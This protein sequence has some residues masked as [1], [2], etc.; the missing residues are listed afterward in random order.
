MNDTEAAEILNTIRQR[1]RVTQIDEPAWIRKLRK[2]SAATALQ[3]LTKAAETERYLLPAH[4]DP[5]EPGNTTAWA[6]E[7]TKVQQHFGRLG[8]DGNYGNPHTN[9]AVYASRH[10]IRNQPANQAQWT[11]RD[12]YE[13]AANNHD[14]HP[15]LETGATYTG[16]TINRRNNSGPQLIDPTALLPERTNQ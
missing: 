16:P 14:T 13:Q 10:A 12:H 1:Q 6:I 9:T 4:L 15:Q 11:F 3:R 7:W 2:L 8:P 5:P